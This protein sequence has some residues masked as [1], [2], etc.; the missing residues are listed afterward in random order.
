MRSDWF[1]VWF[2]FVASFMFPC[3]CSYLV[4]ASWGITVHCSPDRREATRRWSTGRWRTRP[5]RPSPS[6]RR[7]TPSPTPPDSSSTKRSKW[8]LSSS[9]SL[10]N[11]QR[12]SIYLLVICGSLWL[13]WHSLIDETERSWRRKYPSLVC[14]WVF[15]IYR[16]LR[17][18]NSWWEDGQL[19][20]SFEGLLVFLAR[21]HI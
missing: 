21:L 10:S 19:C 11:L 7:T 8:R 2:C 20:L 9:P 1:L 3:Q 6:W 13:C 16:G 17:F 15:A 18:R 14:S 4:R 12:I 5:H